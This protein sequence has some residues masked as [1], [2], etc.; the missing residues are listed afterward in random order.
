[1]LKLITTET[2]TLRDD[3]NGKLTGTGGSGTI[4]Y[5]KGEIS[6]TF[7]NAPASSTAITGDYRTLTRHD[8]AQGT[9]GSAPT[10]SQLVDGWDLFADTDLV[11]VNILIG[12]GQTNI[13]VQQK[14]VDLAED[15]GDAIAIL[16]VPATDEDP[17]KA[18]LWRNITQN[19]NSTYAALYPGR[20]LVQVQGAPKAQLL[21]RSGFEAAV[22]GRTVPPWLP[23]AGVRRGVM[24]VLGVSRAYTQG[25]RDLLYDN[26]LN[27]YRV[28]PG[29]GI[30][31]WGQKTL[32][33]SG[34]SSALSRVNVRRLMGAI[35]GPMATALQGFV[36][37]LNTEFT[38]LQV[39]QVLGDF[40]T[41]IQ[42]QG[43]VYDF[44][45]VCD[46][47]NNPPSVIGAN[48]MNV[49]VYLQPVLAAEFIRLQ[50]VITRTGVNFAE[51]IQ[52]GGNFV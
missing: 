25:E 26:Q 27:P 48:E 35:K 17:G 39:E 44:Q 15:R 50:P 37:Q 12:G 38:R 52:T 47:S 36:H 18:V 46:T 10:A 42:N 13:T 9:D 43:G 4:N 2:I 11:D 14:M 41:R 22:Y 34:Q 45:V 5:A 16:D 30:V 40:M 23:P 31:T 49:D 19:F 29:S 20:Y 7:V 8:L 33:G 21:P 6:Y 51:L 1:M 24:P 3:G 28:I 32:Q